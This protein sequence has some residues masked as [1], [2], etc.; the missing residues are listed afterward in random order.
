MMLTVVVIRTI[1]ATGY[2]TINETLISPECKPIRKARVQ[3]E[4]G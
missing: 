3:A 1:A 4:L 2:L